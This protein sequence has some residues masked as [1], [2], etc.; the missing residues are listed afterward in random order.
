MS[1]PIVQIGN[2]VLRK[3]SHKIPRVTAETRR[4]TDE[5]LETMRETHGVG[6]AA[7]QVGELVQHHGVGTV[8]HDG[9]Q[10]PHRSPF[11]PAANT[12]GDP[13]N[14]RYQRAYVEITNVCNLRCGFC[15]PPVRPAAFVLRSEERRVGKEC[16]SR[17]SPYH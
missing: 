13:V 7:P 8:R 6:L 1:L 12:A 14:R 9:F 3:K 16:R 15:A 17:W 4:L 11:L 10:R 2:P 5:M